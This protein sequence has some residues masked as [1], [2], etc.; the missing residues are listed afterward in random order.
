MYIRSFAAIVAVLLL[1][2]CSIHPVPE[3]VTGV[4]T[5]HIARQIRCETREAVKEFLLRELRNFA[6]GNENVPGDPKAQQLVA[7]Y[8]ADPE[9]ISTFKPDLFPGPYY[10]QVRNYY[11][12]IYST[13]IAYSFDLT[14]TEDNNLGTNLN[15]LGP[16]VP[17]FTL[18]L[19]ADANRERTNERTFTLTD[20][21]SELLTALSIPI[22]GQRYCNGQIVQANYIYPIAGQIG[23][24]TMVKTFFELNAFTNLAS[25]GG[26]S[27]K[28]GNAAITAP[29]LTDKLT[30]TT[31]IDATVAPKVTFTPAGKGFQFADAAVTGVAKRSDTHKVF[32]ALA[33]PPTSTVALTSLRNY[34]FSTQ[35][36]ATSSGVLGPAGRRVFIGNSLTARTRSDAENLA[37]AAVD[38]LRSREIQ[39]IANQ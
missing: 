33:V 30:F 31:T 21:F 3:D 35:R 39:L 32:V 38:Q 4:T 23:V 37:L 29:T 15:L 22:R 10:A 17:K 11:N 36:S 8:E 28:S 20:T 24:Y 7:K 26:G 19:M 18:G 16:W 5:Y 25:N 12:V 14:M 2:G 6:N 34:L 13:A 27:S 1:C 9:A